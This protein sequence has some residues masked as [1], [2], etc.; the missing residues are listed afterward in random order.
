LRSTATAARI[1][2]H[3]RSFTQRELAKRMSQKSWIGM[4]F[5]TLVVFGPVSVTLS[6]PHMV[7]VTLRGRSAITVT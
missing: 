4:D 2:D 5:V 7:F 3:W 6:M 1:R